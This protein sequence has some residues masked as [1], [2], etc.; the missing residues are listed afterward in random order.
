MHKVS[1]IVPVCNSEQY[2]EKCMESILAQ[3]LED[4][5]IICI[6]DGS[7]DNSGVILDAYASKDSRVRVVHQANAG[8][9]ISMNTGLD[10]AAG[11]FIGIVESDDCIAVDMYETL[12]N[13][14]Q[15]YELDMVKADAY[16]WLEKANY[17]SNRHLNNLDSY[18][19]KVLQ[20]TDRNVF[21][22]FFMNIWTGIYRQNFL[23]QKNIRFQE[24]PGAS[25]QDNGFWLQ[26]CIYAERAMWIDKAFYYYRQDNPE[27]SV[28]STKKMMAMTNE[29][30]YI[31]MLLKQRGDER[32]LPYCY[33]Y[34]LVRSRG[35]FYRIA[36]EYKR[37][38]CEQLTTD[39]QKYKAYIKDNIAIDKWFRELVKNP[40]EICNQMIA[41]KN[42]IKQKLDTCKS[43]IIYGAGNRGD[44][45]LRNLCN[46]GYYH[47]IACFAVSKNPP[48]NKMANRDIL[49][50]ED[51]LAHYS[52]ALVIIAVVKGSEIYV[53]MEQKLSEL[54]IHEYLAGSNI[55]KN[56]Y[57]I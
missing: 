42:E 50:I 19:N 48:K 16:Y 3:S 45:I 2:I 20:E 11:E 51:A 14:A 6:D 46:E 7:T 8:Y 13:A 37:M 15:Q 43:I 34:R 5:E 18:Y 52:D 26:T 55:E 25:Y 32:F 33:M 47:K 36:D 41:E 4:I 10:M 49:L 27:A 21:F 9:G 12:Y 30:K 23:K 17:L 1:V 56:F 24:T 22:D 44:R 54:G 39:Y 35:T 57:I 28:K 29:Y 38:F 53:Q 31:E 40:D